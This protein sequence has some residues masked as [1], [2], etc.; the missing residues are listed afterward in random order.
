VKTL[1]V[2]N[3]SNCVFILICFCLV[4]CAAS[5]SLDYQRGEEAF[6][7]EN[8]DEA[9]DY[10]SRYIEKSPEDA[11][12]HL[13]LGIAFLKKGNLREAVDQFKES[14]NLNPE[15]T[16]APTLIKESI[17]DE[18][19]RFFSAGKNDIG[20]RYLTAYLTINSDDVETHILLAKEFIKMGSTRNAI[21]SLNKAVALD[22]KNPEVVELLDYFSDGFH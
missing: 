21:S 12:A 22:P 7:S 9:I 4:S 15:N 14:I 6:K 3:A 20:M 5:R 18:A 17:F 13:K 2:R 19:N 16:E 8:Y 10:L 11:D 1:I